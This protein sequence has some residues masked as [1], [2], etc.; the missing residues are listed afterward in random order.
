VV[1]SVLPFPVAFIY[2]ARVSLV[3]AMPDIRLYILMEHEDDPRKCTAANLVRHGEA[4]RA[5]AIASIPR[6]AVVL[7]PEAE[8]S[9]SAEDLPIVRKLGIL[10]LDCSWKKLERFPRIKTG[11]RHRAIPFTVAANPVNF[12][13]PQMLTTAEALA[14]SV[15]ILGEKGQAH[16]LMSRFRWGE[17][18]LD[19]NLERLEAYSSAA[20][21]AEV[22][23]A[24]ERA[25]QRL[26]AAKTG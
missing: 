15:Y 7:D 21:S 4:R 9:I 26:I 25:I 5:S 1:L 22:V 18:F 10:A 12:G 8:R 19:I 16:R 23:E 13:K 2:T 11:L 17:T 6:G 20:T 14:A 24:Q 3:V